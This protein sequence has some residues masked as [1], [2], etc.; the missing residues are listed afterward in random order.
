MNFHSRTAHKELKET[1]PKDRQDSATTFLE[2]QM[3]LCTLPPAAVSTAPIDFTT[4][5]SPC[6]TVDLP[7]PEDVQTIQTTPAS[8]TLNIDEMSGQISLETSPESRE[9]LNAE[10]PFDLLESWEDSPLS[11]TALVEQSPS[12]EHSN[13]YGESGIDFHFGTYI[14]SSIIDSTLIETSEDFFDIF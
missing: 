2:N 7:N 14:P 10:R 11:F 3:G 5:T 9:K 13:T 6:S 12:P 4:A 1:K 8:S